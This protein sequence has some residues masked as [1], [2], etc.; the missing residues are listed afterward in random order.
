MASTQ[1]E[2]MYL[3]QASLDQPP[4]FAGQDFDLFLTSPASEA[5]QPNSTDTGFLNPND[6]SIKREVDSFSPFPGNATLARSPRGSGS[7]SSSSSSQSPVDHNRTTSAASTASPPAHN[8]VQGTWSSGINGFS[9]SSNERLL[10]DTSMACMDHD[11]EASNRQM[12]SDFDFDTAASTP[13]GFD[14]INAGGI[15]RSLVAPPFNRPNN[16]VAFGK[17]VS[18]GQFPSDTQ[19]QFFFPGS[20]EASPFNA[21]LSSA[22]GQSPWRKHSPSSGLEETFNHITMNGDSPGNATLSP[23]NLQFSTAGF[24]FDPESSATPSTFTK[25]ISSPPSTVNS[26]E[27]APVLTVHPTSLKSRVETQIPIRLTLSSLPSGV[28]KLRLPRHT[29]SK[30]KFLA[31]PNVDRS[32]EILELH[33]SL[34]C[35]SAMQDPRKL[36]RAWARARGEELAPHAR[37]GPGSTDS[38][39]SRD[40]EDK[41]LNGGEVRI[42]AGCIQRE[43]KRASRKKQKKPEEEELFQKDEERRVV[44]FNTN[45]IKEWVEVPRDTQTAAPNGVETQPAASPPGAMQVELPMRIACYCRHQNEKMGFQVIFTINDYRD[46][47]VAQ[48]MTNPIMITDDHK[49]HNAPAAATTTNPPASVPTPGPKLPGAGV[50]PTSGPEQP[51]MHGVNPKMF[52]QSFSTT[53]LH[54]LQH[55]F[56]PNFPMTPASSPF[57][58]SSAISSQTSTTLAPRNLSRPV[59]PSGLSGPTAKRRKQS[60]SGKLPSGLTMTRLDTS[61]VPPGPATMPNTAASSPYAPNMASYMGPADRQ[62]A[63][64]P[65]RPAPFGTSPPTPNGSDPSFAANINRSFSLENLPRQAMISAPPSRQPSRPGSPG[66]AR[67]SFGTAD[68][69]FGQAVSNQLTGPPVRRTPPLIHK[70]VPAEGSVT[71]GTEVT[72]LGN[73]FYQGLEVMFGDTEATTTTFWGE[74]CLNCIAPPAL[75]PGVVA[76]VFKHDHPQYSTIQQQS[77]SRPSLF[78]YVDDRELEMFRLALR[79]LGKQMQHPTDDPYLAAQQLLQGQSHSLWSSHGSYAMNG[80]HQRSTGP[81]GGEAPVDTRELDATMLR[82]LEHMNDQQRYKVPR[83]DLRRPSGLTLLHLASSLG[84]ARFVAGLLSRG[85]DPNVVD[86]NGHTP[87]HHAAMNGNTHVIHQLRLAGADPKIRSIRHFTPADLATSLL[88]YQATMSPIEHYRSRS[89]GGDTPRRL[90]SRSSSSLRSFWDNASN[91]YPTTDT[92]ESDDSDSDPDSNDQ[93]DEDNDNDNNNNDDDEETPTMASSEDL[94]F[95]QPLNQSSLMKAGVSMEQSRRN[96]VPHPAPQASI[97]PQER[98]PD[99]APAV[100]RSA[101]MLAWRDHLVAQLQQF[102]ESAQSV[103]PNLGNL[104]GPIAALQEYQAYPM[105]RRVSSLFPQRPGS[106]QQPSQRERSS[107]PAP[108]SSPPAYG[109]LYPDN[110]GSSTAWSVKK[111]SALVAATDA[112]ADLH[113]ERQSTNQSS[114]APSSPSIP[115]LSLRK[116]VERV[117]LSRDRK[118]FFFWVCIWVLSSLDSVQALTSSDPPPSNCSGIDDQK[119]RYI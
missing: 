33:T 72:L 89:A 82:V 104:N 32:A 15:K 16:F 39:N 103:M 20:R 3:F 98:V 71:G 99:A 111:S 26:A 81:P 65:S 67:N 10:E 118:L 57:A 28:R 117:E 61:Q 77:Q 69:A 85:A 29:V 52:K 48:A 92:G 27:G 63:M 96:S 22:Q 62:F 51:Q 43:R 36:Q 34:V 97:L 54:G 88:A 49:T 24:S 70:L 9:I 60:G 94:D 100:A 102:N 78:T 44:V 55:N 74:K 108:P 5:D 115:G 59:S 110:E 93:D 40:D 30:P 7:G 13:S 50:F 41:P 46:K 87:M 113:F 86:N 8:A 114:E 53:D 83:F 95:P 14:V 2:D 1:D 42:C 4:S 17:P 19:R 73:G 101:F 75:Q 84:L 37:P 31:K 11:F 21:M 109:D 107:P 58:I 106:R 90:H 68:A 66:S 23:P 12:A 45:E 56:N 6:L 64:P 112:A 47:V 76:V 79:A 119:L 91:H 25:D 80:G 35:T 116:P 38:T 18:T 105:V